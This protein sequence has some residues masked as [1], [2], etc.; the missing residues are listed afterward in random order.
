[1]AR[2]KSTYMGIPAYKRIGGHSY[3]YH[4]RYRTKVDA[5]REAR[6]LKSKMG[7]KT[8]I[9]TLPKSLQKGIHSLE[10]VKYLLYVG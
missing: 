1:M 6:Y 3:E 7:Y 4:S 2:I 5:E 10:G 8:R 9:V